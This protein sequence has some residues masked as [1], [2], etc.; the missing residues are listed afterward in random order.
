MDTWSKQLIGFASDLSG[1]KPDILAATARL[2][3]NPPTTLEAIGF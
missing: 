1:G 3:A 2:I